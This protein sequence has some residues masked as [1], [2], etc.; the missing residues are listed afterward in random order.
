MMQ[1]WQGDKFVLDEYVMMNF[2]CLEP[3]E[4]PEEL[5]YVATIKLG[6]TLLGPFDVKI[7]C[8]RYDLR[9]RQPR[10]L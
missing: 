9:G 2:V 1:W 4:E 7:L 6:S 10:R 8:D 5:R 3:E